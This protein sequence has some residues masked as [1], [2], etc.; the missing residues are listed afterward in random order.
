MIRSHL[1]LVKSYKC[2][3][4]YI[5]L[6]MTEIRS[7]YH[8]LRVSSLSSIQGAVCNSRA[9]VLYEIQHLSVQLNFPCTKGF[10]ST[11]EH[12]LANREGIS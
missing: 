11:E 8:H 7:S 4:L 2:I 3:S 1:I 12:A 6:E 5:F 9:C 10:C